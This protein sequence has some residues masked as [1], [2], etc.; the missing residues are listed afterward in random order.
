MNKQGKRKPGAIGDTLSGTTKV[1]FG[2]LEHCSENNN[3]YK[4]QQNEAKAYEK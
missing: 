4:V 3:I 2:H 1:Q